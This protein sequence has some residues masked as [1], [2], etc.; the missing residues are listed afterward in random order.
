MMM[1]MM[2]AIMM[3][4]MMTTTEPYH[5]DFEECLFVK[6][7]LILSYLTPHAS[8]TAQALARTYKRPCC[9]ET[10][11]FDQHIKNVIGKILFEEGRQKVRKKFGISQSPLA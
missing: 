8:Q 6:K 10:V 5:H 11:T 4:V 2:V 7:Y 1:V 9:P 3:M